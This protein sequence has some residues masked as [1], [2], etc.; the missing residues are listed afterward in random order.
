MLNCLF[1]LHTLLSLLT[2]SLD[3][4]LTFFFGCCSRQCRLS[5]CCRVVVALLVIVVIASNAPCCHHY[6][7]D[8]RCCCC[9]CRLYHCH[10]RYYCCQSAFNA[11]LSRDWNGMREKMA[12]EKSGRQQIGTFL[13]KGFFF[14]SAAPIERGVSGDCCRCLAFGCRGHSLV[15]HLAKA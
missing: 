4:Q 5:R 11:L 2:L 8:N 10:C 3:F 9:Y 15:G 12:E 7:S 6:C 13:F 14:P 1:S